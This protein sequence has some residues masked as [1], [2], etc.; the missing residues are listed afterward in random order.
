MSQVTNVI[1]KAAAGE[2]QIDKLNLLLAYAC[3][4]V[5]SDYC[6]GDKHLEVNIYLGAFNHLDLDDFRRTVE[7][8]QWD[9]PESLQL[10]IQEDNDERFR[11]VGLWERQ[12]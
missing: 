4:F 9:Y 11:E 5:D 6:A 1:L 7:S 10:F 2:Y 3:P 8:V 12:S